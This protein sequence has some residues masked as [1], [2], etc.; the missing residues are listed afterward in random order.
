[1][2]VVEIFVGIDGGIFVSLRPLSLQHFNGLSN[3]IDTVI[4][5]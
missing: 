1:V 2:L 5:E 3:E 4:V